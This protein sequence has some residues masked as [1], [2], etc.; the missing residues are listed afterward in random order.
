M[1]DNIS[2]NNIRNFDPRSLLDSG[3]PQL[4]PNINGGLKVYFRSAVKSL[5]GSVSLETARQLI[6]GVADYESELPLFSA[7]PI[8]YVPVAE[9]P[10]EGLRRTAESSVLAA[11]DNMNY[12]LG[13]FGRLAF[14]ADRYDK[15]K[16]R[17]ATWVAP[18]DEDFHLHLRGAS[19][20]GTFS[21][22]FGLGVVDSNNAS[23]MPVYKE[24]WRTGIDTVSVDDRI[25]ARFIR[26]GSGVKPNDPFKTVAFEEF[27]K[28]HKIMPQR[29]LGVLGL[30]FMRELEPA[31][32]LALNTEGARR[33]ST[34]GQS[35]GGCDY[36]GI[37]RN[38]GFEPTSDQYW[39]SI[40]NFEEGFYNAIIAARIRAREEPALNMATEALKN[41]KPVYRHD[42]TSTRRR[43][44]SICTDE[45]SET[46][47][48]EIEVAY[49]TRG[50]GVSQVG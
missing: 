20:A 24:L 26:T 23:Q 6:S 34:L 29:L 19:G 48:R 39:L 10:E 1:L 27:R 21:I 7:Q 31:Y 45:R 16:T 12:M 35:K 5:G 8:R 37:F 28:R 36:D 18:I 15:R 17:A 40:P 33:Y 41:M 9:I 32:A 30:Y 13:R 42:K 46:L 25:G 4:N 44:F 2:S 43:L 14:A 49:A 38:I 47:A 11:T 3:M 22:D 50:R